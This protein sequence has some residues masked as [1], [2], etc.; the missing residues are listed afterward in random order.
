MARHRFINQ[1]ALT[2]KSITQQPPQGSVAEK[3][4][5]GIR[6]GGGERWNEREPVTCLL[7]FNCACQCVW[8][9]NRVVTCLF[10]CCTA[11]STKLCVQAEVINL[12]RD[13]SAASNDFPN[14]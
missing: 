10:V 11:C 12:G 14:S 7:L 8:P 3:V 6:G 2:S 5:R 13:I 4:T 9:I 1:R